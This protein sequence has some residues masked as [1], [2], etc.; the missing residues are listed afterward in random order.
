MT[1]PISFE[2]SDSPP[3]SRRARL[4]LAIMSTLVLLAT[5]GVVEVVVLA[6]VTIVSSGTNHQ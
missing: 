3:G 4:V 5:I 1:G 2:A 6:L